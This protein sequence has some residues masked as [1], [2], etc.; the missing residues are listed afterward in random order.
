MQDPAAYNLAKQAILTKGQAKA[1]KF[2]KTSC[3]VRI[4]LISAWLIRQFLE[5]NVLASNFQALPSFVRSI[6][7][8]VVAVGTGG[9]PR[10]TTEPKLMPCAWTVIWP[11]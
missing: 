9:Q 11:G 8:D 3:T 2:S 7:A 6:V 4:A 10:S 5:D 1:S